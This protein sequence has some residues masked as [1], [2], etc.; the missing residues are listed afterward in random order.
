MKKIK[1]T[2]KKLGIMPNVK[3]YHY[4]ATAIEMCI[5]EFRNNRQVDSW[6]NMYYDIAMQYGTT[7]PRVE[8]C[9]RSAI[10]KATQTE[11][12][13][14]VIRD[15]TNSAFIALVTEYIMEENDND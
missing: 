12:Y 14:K 9:I 7:R 15:R 1:D 6:M 2:L 4:L 10:E 8:R 3:G 5:F 11:L 13:L